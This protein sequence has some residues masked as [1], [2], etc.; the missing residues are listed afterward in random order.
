LKKT[1]KILFLNGKIVITIMET[2]IKI[3]KLWFADDRIFIRTECG[4]ERWQSLLWYSRLRNATDEQRSN[5]RLSYSGIHWPD[6]DE[7]ISFESFF[8]D[9]PEPVGLSRIFL[10][11]PELNVSAIARRM[12]MK[13]SL[14]ASYISGRKKPSAKREEQ[15][16]NSVRQIGKE[17]LSI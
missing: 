8:Y 1:G 10:N 15:I 9:N 6:V 2:E 16:L 14:L 5:Y 13:Q 17:L 11:H 3:S 7:D 12:G 4:S